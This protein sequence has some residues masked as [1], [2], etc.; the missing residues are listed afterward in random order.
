VID[1]H[2]LI[3]LIIVVLP[4][5]GW[6]AIKLARRGAT[7]GRSWALRAVGQYDR[8]ALSRRAAVWLVASSALIHLVLAVTHE[9][10]W[11]TAA[12]LAG[13]AL[14]AVAARWLLE[15][16]RSR[17][18]VAIVVGSIVG[19]WIFGAPP[20]QV[21]MV[22]KLLE[23][24]ALALLAV[25]GGARR[26]APTGVI[27]L[28]MLTGIAAWIG[29]FSAAGEDGGHHGGEY[30]EPGTVVPYI[31]RLEA[32]AAETAA[33]DALYAE[34][35][36][37]SEPYRDP[38]AARAAGYQ[39]GEI[40]GSDYHAQNPDLIGDGRILDPRY[41]ESLIYAES[42]GGPVLVG[43]LFEM[44]GLTDPGPRVGGPITV[45]HRHENI[46]FSLTPPALAGL[47]SPYGVCPLGSVNIPSTGEMLHAWV[48]PGV[49]DEDRWGHVDEEWLNRSLEP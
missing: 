23:L 47:V 44:D 17:R 3:A 39:V 16:R 13:A 8:L 22:T 34:L 25:P 9:P 35:L 11:Y 4:L 2:A 6:A 19:F 5:L 26:L 7:A 21:S 18:V 30:P 40:H 38:D 10:S 32:T 45:W 1:E 12:Y 36:V 29:A 28:V 14:L 42:V 27:A 48:M 41:P 20:D 15:G 37:A 24:F 43:V 49:P 31:D 46:C 33:A